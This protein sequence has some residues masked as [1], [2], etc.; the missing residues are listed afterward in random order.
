MSRR[1]RAGGDRPLTVFLSANEESADALGAGLIEALAE[2]VDGKVRCVGV[3]GRRMIR[4]GLALAL[5]PT[6]DGL[7][8][9]SAILVR[10]PSLLLRIRRTAAAVIDADPDVLVLIDAPYFNL[11]VAKMVRR[12]NPG[13]TIIDYVSPTVWAHSPGRARQMTPYV[14]HILSI[15][16]FEPAVHRELGGPP[17]TFV[18]HPALARL[19]DLR[20]KPGERAPL[21]DADRPVLLVLPGSR[22]SE[23]SRLMEPFGETLGLIY[24]RFGRVEAVLPA[25]A[26][27]AE[28]ISERAAAWPVR[29]R[30]VVGD[31]AKLAAFR[32]AHAALAASGTVTLELALAHVPMVVAYRVDPLLRLLKRL[33]TARSIVLANVIIDANV[34]P[35][36]LD[37]DAEPERLCEALLPLLEES[38]E[39]ARQLAAF[40]RVEQLMTLDQD[41][42]SGYAADTV[43]ETV[44]R[45]RLRAALERS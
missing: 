32:R 16:P 21:A 1:A 14:D 11:R 25:V 44:R 13:I 18:G 43:I 8:G 36:F 41:T 5:P 19:D 22:L 4:A 20:P 15:L 10:L 35:E 2:R 37:G 7:H 9:I 31:R 26:H 17:C 24:E 23:I 28:E 27:L 40:D 30:I 3:G 29:P 6:A 34:V 12:A 39:R 33:L 38:P 42:P 45:R